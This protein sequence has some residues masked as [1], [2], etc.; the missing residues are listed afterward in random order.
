VS[1]TDV[2]LQGVRKSFGGRPAVDGVDLEVRRGEFF[3]L[4]GPSGCGKTTLMRL[5]AG[6]EAPDAGRIELAGRDMAG[7]PPHRRDVNLVFQNYAL[8]PHL[9]VGE[10][11]AFGLRL[12]GVPDVDARVARALDQVHLPGAQRRAVTTLSGGE[13]QRVALA[14]AVVTGPRV[15]LLD[16]PLSALDRQLR[17]ALRAELR[18]LQRELGMTF[19]LVTHDQ[20]EALALSDR[21]AVLRNGRVEQVGPPAEVYERPSTRFVAGFVGAGNFFEGRGDGARVR[22]PDGLVIEAP[23]EGDVVLLVRPERLRLAPGHPGLEAVVEEVLYQGATTS[24]L[25]RAGARTLQVDDPAARVKPGDRT[26]LSWS[27]ADARVLRP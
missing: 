12:A 24:V 25:L 11:V 14:R 10:N 5:V 23:A 8:F 16:E 13:Q 15:L 7:V 19:I 20:E 1:E 21:I 2:R 22:T 18:H 9:D 3:S 17:V 27:P 26:P 4:L 6:F